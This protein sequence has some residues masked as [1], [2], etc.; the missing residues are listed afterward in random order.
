[1]RKLLTLFAL[2]IV[3]LANGS[4]SA[5]ELAPSVVAATKLGEQLSDAHDACT[6]SEEANDIESIAAGNPSMFR[7]I[8]SRSER[9][10]KAR[11]AY[12]RYAI[13]TCV[14][15]NVPRYV[16]LVAS[17]Y[18]DALTEEEM[19]EI[20][21]FYNSDTGKKFAE[22]SVQLTSVLNKRMYEESR[23]VREKGAARF[24]SE[25]QGISQASQP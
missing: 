4:A 10:S 12:L 14:P 8:D 15:N 13:S 16:E 2:A 3:V 1:M 18:E 5:G 20:L 24:E 17:F 11:A 22:I 9:W 19:S 23:E 7:G 25:I 6:V 21:E